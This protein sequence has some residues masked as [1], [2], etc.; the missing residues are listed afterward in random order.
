MAAPTEESQLLFMGLVSMLSEN[1]FM[2]LGKL[3]IPGQDEPQVSLP[4]A[5]QLIGTLEVL[6]ARTEGKLSTQERQHLDLNL[7]NLRLNYLEVEKAE[8]A[9]SASDEEAGEGGETDS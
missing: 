9:P 2:A 4:V 5:R 6:Q 7:T 3:S 1:A 8:A